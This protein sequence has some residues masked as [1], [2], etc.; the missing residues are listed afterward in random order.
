MEFSLLTYNVLFN[1]ACEGLYTVINTTQPDIICLQ[2]VDTD[3]ANLR[4][5]EKFGYRL[6]DYSNSFIK[7][8]KIFG[9]AT[10]YN[11]AR[12]EF[13]ESTKIDLPKSFSELFLTFWRVFRGGNKPRTILETHLKDRISCKQI[14]VFNVHLTPVATNQVRLKQIKTVTNSMIKQINPILIAGDFNYPYGRKRL[15][16]TMNEYELKEAT[17]NI[18]YSFTR[19]ELWKF[20][21]F[22]VFLSLAAKLFPNQFKQMKNDYVFYKGLKCIETNMIDFQYSDH[23]PIISKFSF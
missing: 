2:E 12:F 19:K 11:P 5:I 10:F 13:K 21:I 18:P 6:A 20:N 15:E 4:R 22:V 16:E 9:V 23:F 3:E 14:T 8:G 7:F 1:R 17:L